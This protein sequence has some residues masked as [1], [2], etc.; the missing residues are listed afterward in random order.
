MA[1]LERSWFTWV[2]VWL[3]TEL[4]FR[5]PMTKYD[6]R[7]SV[8]RAFSAN[9]LRALVAAAGWENAAHRRFVP[10]R[11]AAW[12]SILEVQPVLAYDLPSPNCAA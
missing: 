7:L 2:S 11:Q 9:E 10:A 3:V 8:R 4:I 5:D 1:D 12:I 6:G